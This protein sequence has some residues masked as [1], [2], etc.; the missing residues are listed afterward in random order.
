M[1]LWLQSAVKMRSAVFYGWYQTM[2]GKTTVISYVESDAILSRGKS[3]LE[4]VTAQMH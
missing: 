2:T 1:P 3:R 4:M